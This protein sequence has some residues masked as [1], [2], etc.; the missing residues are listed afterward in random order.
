M[1][2]EE[3]RGR[4][5]SGQVWV[6]SRTGQEVVIAYVNYASGEVAFAPP[7]DGVSR[8]DLGEFLREFTR[9]AVEPRN[10]DPPPQTGQVIPG[11]I[12][13]NLSD[14]EAR[15]IV[16]E[17]DRYRRR[18]AMGHNGHNERYDTE[19]MS[20]TMLR[21]D[22][23]PASNRC[24]DRPLTREQAEA[25]LY[26][27]HTTRRRRQARERY[28]GD[29]ARQVLDNYASDWQGI[30]SRVFAPEEIA[31]MRMEMA[32]EATRLEA[33][34][35]ALQ[36]TAGVTQIDEERG[37]DGRETVT[38]RFEGGSV[39]F[40][41]WQLREVV[42]VSNMTPAQVREATQRLLER[43]RIRPPET[44]EV[45]TELVIETTVST[46]RRGRIRN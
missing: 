13:I 40:D 29:T 4:P 16:V 31:R 33:E 20:F 42:D 27:I 6:S 25:V 39:T 15:A 12:W 46:Q 44:Q 37:P 7:S 34:R 24:N 21:S 18:V 36:N 14:N 2:T 43:Y 30:A 41:R 3:D 38:V 26:D 9:I 19:W 8:L 28:G 22:W 32:A 17:V 45:R 23:R 1:P 10:N 11:Q 5:E 35:Q